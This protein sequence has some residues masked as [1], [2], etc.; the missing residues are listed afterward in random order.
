MEGAAGERGVLAISVHHVRGR[1]DVETNGGRV[2]IAGTGARMAG[3]WFPEQG[4]YVSGQASA[5]LY[6]AD[7]DSALDGA[8]ASDV[9]GR[10][11]AVGVEAGRRL[12]LD[13]VALTP[14]AGAGWSQVEMSSFTDSMGERVSLDAGRRI[15]A[16]AGLRA[17]ADA[18]AGGVFATVDVEREL[19]GSMRA[20]AADT[21]L[22]AEAEATWLRLG[23]G[24]A[25]EWADGRFV[26]RGA[27]NYAAARRGNRDFAGYAS[28]TVR[29]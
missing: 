28:L 2:E 14:R 17:E 19:S 8:L 1:A 27:A 6:E 10:G 23:L 5:T 15:T 11:Y 25:H 21:P 9:S 7:L 16:R 12:N 29:F 20:A 18:L 13:R 22:E 4:F 3:A 26:L 24:G